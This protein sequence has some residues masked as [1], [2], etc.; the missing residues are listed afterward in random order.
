MSLDSKQDEVTDFHEF[1]NSFIKTHEATTTETKDYKDRILSHAKPLYNKYLDAYK[2]NY[3]REKVK[4][5]E[6][7]EHDYKQFQI[8]DKKKNENQSGLKKKLREKCKSYYGLK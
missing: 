3:D 1:L 6:K 8:I 7:R 5:E 4:K 2:K